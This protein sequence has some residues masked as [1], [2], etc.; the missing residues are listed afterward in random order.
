MRWCSCS[1]RGEREEKKQ[2]RVRYHDG[3]PGLGTHNLLFNFFK[4]FSLVAQFKVF[5][6]LGCFTDSDPFETPRA[7]CN[8]QLTLN[9]PTIGT[10]LVQPFQKSRTMLRRRRETQAAKKRKKLEDEQREINERT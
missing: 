6:F 8:L 2:Q 1:D 4:S 7:S 5:L 9:F 3:L 10:L